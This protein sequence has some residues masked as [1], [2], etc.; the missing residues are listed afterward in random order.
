MISLFLKDLF[1]IKCLKQFSLNDFQ[2]WSLKPFT[3]FSQP[4]LSLFI[5]LIHFAPKFVYLFLLYSFYL[6]LEIDSRSCICQAHSLTLPSPQCLCLSPHSVCVLLALF[7][8]PGSSAGTLFSSNPA[9]LERPGQ[10]IFPVRDSS[11]FFFSLAS[12]LCSI[13]RICICWYVIVQV[14]WLCFPSG[15][16]LPCWGN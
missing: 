3:N 14:C 6:A 7:D 11:S 16:P 8:V 1:S 5:L 2:H 15:C 13:W 9:N 12:H 10:R 4:Q